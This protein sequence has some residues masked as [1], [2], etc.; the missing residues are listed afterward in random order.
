[1]LKK[2]I[3][4]LLV[5]T[6]LFSFCFSSYAE[7]TASLLVSQDKLITQI[8]EGLQQ[9]KKINPNVEKTFLKIKKYAKQGLDANQVAKKLS[10]QELNELI[11]ACKQVDMSDPRNLEVNNNLFTGLN[12]EDIRQAERFAKEYFD[13]SKIYGKLPVTVDAKANSNKGEISVLSGAVTYD[14]NFMQAGYYLTSQQI[15]AYLA[16][17]S[18]IVG[19]SFPYLGLLAL[20]LGCALIVGGA[21]YL[22]YD[23]ISTIDAQ[24]TSWFGSSSQNIVNASAITQAMVYQRAMY[25]YKYWTAAL[26]NYCGLGGVQVGSPIPYTTARTIITQN[27]IPYNIISIVSTDAIAACAGEGLSWVFHTAHLTDSYG[28]YKPLNLWH[29]HRVYPGGAQGKSHAFFIY[30]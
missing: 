28:N 1:M 4:F 21:M 16:V 22:Y 27:D 14:S 23:Y 7:T 5:V 24:V 3:S 17:L 25:N 18:Q 6:I 10:K 13:Y 29:I 19:Q 11:E 9:L 12:Q 8:D 2:L 20:V 30:Y 15:G 26:A